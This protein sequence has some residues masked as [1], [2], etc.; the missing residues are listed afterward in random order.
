MPRPLPPPQGTQAAQA[1]W[2]ARGKPA[3]SQGLA[4]AR[5]KSAQLNAAIEARAGDS[6]PKAKAAAGAAW[7]AACGAALRAWHSPALAAVRPA[8]A[9]A[10]AQAAQQAAKVQAELEQ[11]LIRWAAA[12]GCVC[13]YVVVVA[14][15]CVCGGGRGPSLCRA[16]WRS[17]RENRSA[18]LAE[19]AACVHGGL[20]CMHAPAPANQR[21]P[22]PPRPCSLLSKHNATVPLARRPYV[23]YMVSLPSCQRCGSLPISVAPCQCARQALWAASQCEAPPSRLPQRRGGLPQCISLRRAAGWRRAAGSPCWAAPPAPKC[24]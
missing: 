14:V 18:A 3:L 12:A 17:H 23:T 9:K 22:P 5:T 7:G 4:L 15:V 11:L 8:L 13:V 1:L 20:A 16:W 2:H 21:G 10:Y 19:R 24:L 6:W